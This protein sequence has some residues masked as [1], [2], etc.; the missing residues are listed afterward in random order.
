V[1]VDDRLGQPGGTR[2][3][4]HVQRVV[5][6]YR[7]E[8]QRLVGRRG[9]LPPTVR[10]TTVQI[11]QCDHV[12]QRGQRVDD[13]GHLDPPVHR[14]VAVPVPVDRDEYL[15]LDLPPPV[16]DAARTELRRTRGEHRAQA[17]GGQHQHQGLRDVGQVRGHPV[18][19][20]HTE[21][22][23]AGAHP[24]DLLPQPGRVQG[25]RRPGLRVAEHHRIAVGQA[26]HAQH[27]FGVVE[28]RTGEPAGAG[29]VGVGQHGRGRG[30]AD[31][32]EVVPD[33]APEPGQVTGGPGPQ[34][35]VVGEVQAA[36]PG[37]PVHEVAD[38]RA[39]P[40]IRRRRPQQVTGSH[41]ILRT[42][43]SGSTILPRP[44]AHNHVGRAY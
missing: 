11:G 40:G 2:G 13:R 10:R 36:L 1:P 31:H 32:L 27:M 20:L 33:G 26:G 9:Q 38:P 3:V 4:E 18:A 37:Q 42:S 39:L 23:Q 41:R 34:R 14:F 6:R 5:E 15:R 24:A 21:A 16:H 30:V 28:R 12:S 44:N 17:G 7:R 19:P 43:P 29:H 8:G 35:R 22:H 25:Y